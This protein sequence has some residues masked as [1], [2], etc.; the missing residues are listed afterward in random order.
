MS[1][2]SFMTSARVSADTWFSHRVMM[3]CEASTISSMTSRDC[4]KV[5]RDRGAGSLGTGGYRSVCRTF[6]ETV[7]YEQ[8]AR[9][10]RYVGLRSFFPRFDL[11]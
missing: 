9:I 11:E 6:N 5:T 7:S 10:F 2:I 4:F 8:D 3:E 1:W